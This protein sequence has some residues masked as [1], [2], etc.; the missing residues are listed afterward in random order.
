MRL[1][2]S[3]VIFAAAVAVAVPAS[4]QGTG[5]SSSTQKPASTAKPKPKKPRAPLGYRAF[6]TLDTEMMT[7]S[8]SFRAVTGSSAMIGFGG[9]GEVLSVWHGLFVRG[10]VS[11]ASKSGERALVA[12][13]EVIPT[14]QTVDIGLTTIE[15]GAGWRMYP[16]KHPKMALYGGGGLLVARYSE[17]SPN[18][19]GDEN[20]KQSFR[21]F[22]V[23]GGLES[24]LSKV[25]TFAV[26]G[27]YRAVPNAI[28]QGGV[29]RTFVEA[30][31][32]SL[33]GLSP[34]EASLGGFTIRVMVGIRIKK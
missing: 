3:T 17:T 15:I 14:G 26:E 5:S 30:A 18:A 8:Q 10:A 16:K 28:G 9:G 25:M 23:Q 21:G 12:F 11:A 27:Q 4:A 13:G 33:S 19:V 29:S 2:I 32:A 22:S 31:G 34:K 20:V 24:A 6:F 1:L 7:A